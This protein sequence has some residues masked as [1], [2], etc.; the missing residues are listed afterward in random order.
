MI[1]IRLDEQIHRQLKVHAA[2]SEQSIQQIV[3]MLVKRF[4]PSTPGK[5]T[6]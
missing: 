2:E 5:K 6:N 3:E 1:H 4:L